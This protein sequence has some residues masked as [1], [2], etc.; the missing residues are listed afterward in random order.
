MDEAKQYLLDV[1]CRQQTLLASPLFQ[2]IGRDLIT[3]RQSNLNELGERHIDQILAAFAE[4]G[5]PARQ[6]IRDTSGIHTIKDLLDSSRRRVARGQELEWTLSAYLIYLPNQD[7]WENRFGER[8]SYADICESLLAD[9]LESGACG[10]T[11]RLYTLAR[12][13]QAGKG[14]NFLDDDLTSRIQDRLNNV[15]NVLAKTQSSEGA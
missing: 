10:G 4:S 11:H 13:L 7:T 12:A 1:G 14:L 6:E 15:V 5:L 3:A 2:R 9:D 8:F